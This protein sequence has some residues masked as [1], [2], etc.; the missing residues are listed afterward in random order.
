MRV[1]RSIRWRLQLWYGALLGVVLIGFGISAHH[2]V[3]LQALE[4]IDAELFQYTFALDDATRPSPPHRRQTP[5]DSDD[6]PR[7]RRQHPKLEDVLSETDRKRGLYYAIWKKNDD[8]NFQSSENA[9]PGIPIPPQ[10]QD[11]FRTRGDFREAFINP[12]PG[13]HFVV[14]RSMSEDRSQLQLLGWKIAAV[15]IGVWSAVMLA[16]WWLTGRALRP[17]G[18]ISAAAE[19]ITR[20]NLSQRIDVGDTETELGDLAGVLNSTFERLDNAFAQQ[21]RF[22]ADA[23]HELRTPVTVILTHVQNSLATEGLSDDNREALEAC[24]RAARRM[25]RL[26]ESLL[27]LARFDAGRESLHLECCNLSQIAAD[28]HE[29]TSPL[30][31]QRKIHIK[32]DLCPA[33]FSGDADR[34]GQV[35][36]NLL[37]NAIYYNR[38]GGRVHLATRIEEGRALCVISDNGPGIS[39]DNLPHIFERFYRADKARSGAAGRNGL[40]L[41]ISQ[42]IAHAHGGEITVESEPG[43]G[44]TFFLR[45]PAKA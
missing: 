19:R 3:A 12:K 30:G 40:G 41:A 43:K 39:P 23:A 9:P 18:A 24:E 45:L 11:G 28:C 20:G 35:I 2:I 17:I 44:S 38:D 21:A 37:T 6:P 16:G 29:L 13:D 4:R 25:R 36:T 42:A 34:I 14:G 22:T 27:Q 33:P 10:D 31:E 5:G 7:P 15:E 26:I 32:T 1:F 8:P